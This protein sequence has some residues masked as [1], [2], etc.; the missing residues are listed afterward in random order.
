MKKNRKQ[1]P[2]G[3]KQPAP[4]KSPKDIAL[5]RNIRDRIEKEKQTFQIQETLILQQCTSEYLVQSVSI[6]V[7][8]TSS[9]MLE[10]WLLNSCLLF[11]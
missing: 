11:K 5:E 1:Q 10:I 7:I 3:T 9:V 4:K 6:P 2:A 8:G